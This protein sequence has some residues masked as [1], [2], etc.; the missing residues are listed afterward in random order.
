MTQPDLPLSP[1]PPP[2]SPSEVKEFLAPPEKFDFSQDPGGRTALHLAIIHSHPSVVG[3]LLDYKGMHALSLTR[4]PSES[5][6][7]E[8]VGQGQCIV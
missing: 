7:A 3:V 2:P 4:V 6:T 1:T 5:I 8:W